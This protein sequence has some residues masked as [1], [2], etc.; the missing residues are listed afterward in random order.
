MCSG[1]TRLSG[2]LLPVVFSLFA[3][4]LYAQ[5]QDELALQKAGHIVEKAEEL[6]LHT[7]PYWHTLLHYKPALFG[8]Y[9]SLVDD[10]KF[11]CAKNGKTDPK[12]EL[13]ATIRSFFAPA[14]EAGSR[15]AIERFPGRYRWLCEKLSLSDSDFP[16][17]G[18]AVFRENM[19]T[20]GIESACLVFSSG[21][22]RRPASLFGHTF[23]I[24]E[25]K[26]A[27]RITAT[28][29][30]YGAVA[31]AGRGVMYAFMGLSGRLP[32]YYAIGPYYDKI[33]QYSDIDMR[34][35]WEYKFN[36]TSDEI[37]RMLRHVYDLRDIY[38]DYFFVSENCSYNLLFPIEAARPETHASDLLK[39]IVEPVES[40]KVLKEI[41]VIGEPEYRPSNYSKI[42]SQKLQFTRKQNRYIRNVCM[43]KTSVQEFPFSDEPVEV[44]A[45]MWELAS[46]YLY[47][48]LAKGKIKPEE[49]RSR[50]VA[51]LSARRKLGKVEEAESAAPLSPDKSH[52]S[53]KLAF[54]GG[55]DA[56]GR[57][58]GAEFRLT[59]HEQLENPAG[60][61]NNSEL[62]FCNIDAR[63][64]FAD[65]KPYLKKALLLSVRSL[66]VSDVF[67]F[68][69]AY[70]VI[71]GLDSN[72]NE[73]GD[74][75]LAGRVNLMGGAST[76]PAPW[77]QL[78]ALGGADAYFSPEYTYSTDVLL[79]G[80]AGFI[81][82][83]G[84]WKNKMAA[85]VMISLFDSDHLR[86]I[87]SAEECLSFSQNAAL[88]AGYSFTADYGTF[89]HGWSVSFNA[90]F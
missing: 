42:E 46:S 73:D 66:P 34:D 80:E 75:D 32:G 13:A 54:S 65:D 50:F 71:A 29:I 35:M 84:I 18:D 45:G 57:Y 10:K 59:A 48:L 17:D 58:V 24:V 41:G 88:K 19:R 74:E 9:K 31:D 7:D 5:N 27:T 33:K 39:G 87:L 20:S 72:L 16:Y 28:A 86:T 25:S 52:G 40:V 47:A 64:S 78:Y 83:A 61:S 43:G 60:Y 1:R 62:S 56:N 85:S 6:S 11:F 67:F 90:Y 3:F 23:L 15:H 37:D 79:G 22:L 12:A 69:G 51:V 8:R 63:Y 44:Q 49:Y 81:T 77:I 14:P 2:C 36:F 76:A 4:Q 89:L 55:K 30:N 53:R 26:S 38:S 82:T 68:N 70:Q 21:Y